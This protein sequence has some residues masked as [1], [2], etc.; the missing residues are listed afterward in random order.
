[1]AA[2][3]YFYLHLPFYLQGGPK[4]KERSIRAYQTSWE[5]GEIQ[6]R[7][8]EGGHGGCIAAT[9]AACMLPFFFWCIEVGGGSPLTSYGK[10]E[11]HLS[12]CLCERKRER[13]LGGFIC[14]YCIL[15]IFQR[16]SGH[17]E[18]VLCKANA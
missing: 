7:Q 10:K 15:P 13:E 12:S 1:M 17:K 6:M 8:L 3:L 4:N 9:A 2:N 5:D 18:K 14:L 11:W 16:A